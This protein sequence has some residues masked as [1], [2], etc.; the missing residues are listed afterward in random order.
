MDHA[1]DSLF[2]RIFYGKPVSTFPEHALAVASF[3]ATPF[4]G[5]ADAVRCRHGSDSEAAMARSATTR[6]RKVFYAT[7]QVTRVEEWFVEAEDAD[8]ARALL[9][10]GTGQRSQSGECI[11]LEIEKLIAEKAGTG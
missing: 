9:E 1:L 8:E 4:R 3:Q 5:I 7:M 6:K 11:H 2:G 10:S